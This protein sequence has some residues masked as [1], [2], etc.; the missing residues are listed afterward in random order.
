MS[1][2]PPE[3]LM[4]AP[5]PSP[6]GAITIAVDEHDVLRALMFDDDAG[7]ARSLRR[8][9]PGVPVTAGATPAAIAA[10]LAAYFAGDLARLQSIPGA[11][12]GTPFQQRVWRALATIPPGTTTTY[13]ALATAIDAPRAVRAV[14]AANGA[15]PISLVLA[16]HR[17]IGGNGRLVGYGGG[18]HRKEWLLAHEGVTLF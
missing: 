6:V 3:R 8:C 13:G 14:G 17:V 7:T 16:C 15:N 11:I 9:Y 5:L 4:M 2:P 1:A 18:L 12:T 10:A